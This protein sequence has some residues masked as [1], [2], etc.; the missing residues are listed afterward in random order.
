M[1]DSRIL[2]ETLLSY[3]EQFPHPLEGMYHLN[4]R[5]F[6]VQYTRIRGIFSNL[7]VQNVG[8]YYLVDLRYP[9]KKGYLSPYKGR[10][11]VSE[12]QHGCTSSGIEG[13]VQS[14]LI[15]QV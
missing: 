13:G 12:W 2:L 5:A 4:F 7:Q 3:K 14:C 15:I 8:K 11:H 6:F 9:N 10:Y 1:H